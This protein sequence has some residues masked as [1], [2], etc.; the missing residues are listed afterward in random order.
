MVIRSLLGVVI[1]LIIILAAY[2]T[3]TFTHH[4]NQNN[5]INRRVIFNNTYCSPDNQD[6]PGIRINSKKGIRYEI[7]S[8]L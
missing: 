5:N 4:G 2:L 1:S 8:D 3:A 7:H 6:M